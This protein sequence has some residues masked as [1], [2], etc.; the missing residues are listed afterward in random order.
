[1]ELE[2]ATIGPHK[3]EHPKTIPPPKANTLNPCTI[4]HIDYKNVHYLN[5]GFGHLI[6]KPC[7][8]AYDIIIW[9]TLLR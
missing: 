9:H 2:V 7:N 1:M 8:Y 6:I 4:V 5:D 3:V